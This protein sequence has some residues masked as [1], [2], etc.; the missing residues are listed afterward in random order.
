MRIVI[1][2]GNYGEEFANTRHNAGYV[3]VDNIIKILGGAW[4]KEGKFNSEIYKYKDIVFIKPQ[5]FMNI[6]GEVVS[7]IYNFYKIDAN[8]LWIAHDDLDIVLGDYKIQKG[9]GP[10]V[11]NGIISVQETIG[12][13]DFWRVRIGID[14]RGGDRSMTGEDYVLQRFDEDEILLLE[15][16]ILSAISDAK[17]LIGF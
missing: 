17:A 10:K 11:H 9:V 2:L 15:K 14:G 7:K 13:S 4:S 3:F 16:T 5:T 1:G 12:T 8:D 6:S